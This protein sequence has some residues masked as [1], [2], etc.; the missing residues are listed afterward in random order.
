MS[1]YKPIEQSF[2]VT[3]E[4]KLHFTE[5]LFGLNN[6]LFKELINDY[7]PKGNVKVLF[8]IDSGVQECHPE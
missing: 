4:Y 7:N 8:V 2:K 6:P 3:Y 5:H 1:H